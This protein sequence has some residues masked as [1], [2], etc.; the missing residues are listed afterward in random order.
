METS[1]TRLGGPTTQ[2]RWGDIGNLALAYS[3]QGRR[4][5][6]EKLGG[7]ADADSQDQ[8]R[9]ESPRHADEHE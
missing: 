2:T 6:A 7:A 9:A 8:A 5:E 3:K 1:K 4:E